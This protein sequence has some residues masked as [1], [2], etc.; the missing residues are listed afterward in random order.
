MQKWF[1]SS[2]LAYL[3]RCCSLHAVSDNSR[4]LCR[5]SLAQNRTTTRDGH[6]AKTSIRR[7]TKGFYTNYVD[8]DVTMA[9]YRDNY[10]ANFERLVSLKA[11]YDP[12]NL[13]RL[14]ANVPPK[15]G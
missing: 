13:F 5:G 1:A 8:S 4:H 2:L 14:N 12:N 9:G 15:I 6:H 10:G 11:K 7:L 3:N